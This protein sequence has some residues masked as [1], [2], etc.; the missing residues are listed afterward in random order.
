MFLEGFASE[1]VESAARPTRTAWGSGP[2]EVDDA[3]SAG[4]SSIQSHRSRFS[5]R[6]KAAKNP[7]RLGH[8]SRALRMFQTSST[9]GAKAPL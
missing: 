4:A 8:L 6:S 3:Q 2:T 7:A 5:R 1:P 9:N